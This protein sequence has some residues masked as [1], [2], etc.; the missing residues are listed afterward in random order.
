[1]TM[2]GI[3]WT[4]GDVSRRGFAALRLS[5]WGAWRLFGRDARYLV[6]VN[7]V[8][9]ARAR[10]LCGPAPPG[11]EWRA[12]RRDLPPWLAPHLE[13]GLAQGVAWKLL[14]ARA[15]PD[16]HELALDNDVIL[17]E[18]PRALDDWLDGRAPFLLAEDV[19]PCF[20]QFAGDCAGAPRNTG[21]RGLPPGF[22]LA[23]ALGAVLAR[24]RAVLVSELDEQG[25]QVAALEAAG[26]VAVVS[27]E[28]VTICSPFPPHVP[29]LGRAGAHF[30]GLNARRLG[31][32]FLGRPGE[33][34][35]AEHWDGCA[36]ALARLTGAPAKA[37]TGRGAP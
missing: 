1:M 17:W 7:S 18:R 22:D 30:V 19:R 28:E 23:A 4:I 21:I 35:R 36:A 27:A 24:R 5:L 13:A 11:I 6:A 15:F 29:H 3:R 34:V 8:P 14:P 25:L 32:E 33:E 10:A 16:R 9:L 26:P 37:A 12:V 31:F 20:G 2:L